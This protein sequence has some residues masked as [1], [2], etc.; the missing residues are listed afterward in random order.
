MEHPVSARRLRNPA[1][2][3]VLVVNMHASTSFPCVLPMLP[4][5]ALPRCVCTA[6]LQDSAESSAT[7]GSA[8]QHLAEVALILQRQQQRHAAAVAAMQQAAG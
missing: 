2:H 8:S 6:H 7:S 1:V 4:M 3:C 5:D